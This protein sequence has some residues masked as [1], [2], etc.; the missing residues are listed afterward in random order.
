MKKAPVVLLLT[1]SIA[2]LSATAQ[3]TPLAPLGSDNFTV[4]GGSTTIAYTQSTTNL[5]LA[6]TI[7]LGDTLGGIF[8]SAYDWSAYSDTNNFSFG[9]FMSAPGASP[10]IGFT[11][12]FFN[13]ALDQIVNAYQGSASGL[14]STPTFIPVTLSSLG[15]DE[16]SS[17]GGLQFTWDG[18]GSGIVTVDS[19]GVAVVPEP[20]TWAMLAFGATL[21]GG[22]ALRRRLATARRGPKIA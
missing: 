14:S 4:D 7:T 17:I 16:L 11:I 13:G 22:L 10:N 1:L 20:S 6:N 3:T 18:A 2:A 9:L 5:T 21:F 15:T 12:E 19:V 8:S